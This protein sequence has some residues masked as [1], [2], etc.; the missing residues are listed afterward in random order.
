MKIAITG[1]TSGLGKACFDYYNNIP[2]IKVKGFSRTSGFDITDPTSIITHMS[3]FQYDVFINNAYDGFAQVN[4]L[5]ELIKVFKGRIVN[6]SSNSSDGIKN[7]VWPYSVHKSA[8]DKA[9]QQ[10]FHNGYNVS[11]I[12]FGWLNTDRVEHIDESK[13]D[14]FDAVNTVDYVVNNINRIETITVLPTGKY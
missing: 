10:L 12:K 4:L 6:I 5:Y 1:H 13:I 14:L 7:K 8:L 3:N 2:T 11:N 9:S